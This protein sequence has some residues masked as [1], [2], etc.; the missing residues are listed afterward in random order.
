MSFV[1]Q[2]AKMTAL[3]CHWAA[4]LFASRIN[5][6]DCVVLSGQLFSLTW[7]VPHLQQSSTQLHVVHKH[8]R[9][10]SVARAKPSALP[11]QPLPANS[12]AWARVVRVGP[13]LSTMPIF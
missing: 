3:V 11:E 2:Q 10:R 1:V 6:D 7:S 9:L 5:K 12:S 4:K 13:P 8:N